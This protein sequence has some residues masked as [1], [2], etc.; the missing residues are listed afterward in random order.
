MF[1]GCEICWS[2]R[3]CDLELQICSRFIEFHHLLTEL[4][5]YFGRKN[6]FYSK[7]SHDL[8][9]SFPEVSGHTWKFFECLSSR[10]SR[11]KAKR[12]S[13]G[14]Q[15]LKPA[16]DLGWHFLEKNHST[17][18]FIII[19]NFDLRKTPGFS[20]K[21]LSAHGV[22]ALDHQDLSLKSENISRIRVIFLT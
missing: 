15:K 6:S 7:I 3:W 21:Y 18:K 11:I 1:S 22:P 4:E 20:G 17:L 13:F 19:S 16:P 14:C 12:L 2:F 8:R 10:L 9:F 5:C